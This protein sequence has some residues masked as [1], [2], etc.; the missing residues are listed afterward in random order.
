MPLDHLT[1]KD[2]AKELVRSVSPKRATDSAELG[3]EILVAAGE[4]STTHFSIV[5]RD[6]NA[7]SNTYTLEESFGSHVM[8]HGAGFI[9][10]SELT[11]FNLHP[12]HTDR[13]GEIGTEPNQIAPG[14]RILSSQTP[15]IVLRDGKVYVV[16][17]SPGSRTIINTVLHIITNVIDFQMEIRE[18]VDAPRLHH[19][20]MPDVVK[21]EESR[22][23]EQA[24]RQL[25]S[26]GHKFEAGGRQGDAHS[27]LVDP[28]TNIRFGAADKRISGK[29]AGY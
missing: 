10:N 3:Q 7:V 14:K 11:D 20:W 19:Q 24:R 4:E 21:I 16:T 8:V 5:D 25:E 23:S 29:A 17:G 27:I 2:Y 9:L 18:A 6:G 12:G 26:M 22:L 13:E 15:T 28:E 1:S